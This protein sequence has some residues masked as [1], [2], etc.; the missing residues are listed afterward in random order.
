MW[1]APTLAVR[2]SDGM[3]QGSSRWVSGSGR[4]FPL[5]VALCSW[6]GM[7]QG[8]GVLD[9]FRWLECREGGLTPQRHDFIGR[10]L[11]S[12]W[13]TTLESI[14]SMR[15][16]W[17][18]VGAADTTAVCLMELQTWYSIPI[19]KRSSSYLRA[20][21]H[22]GKPCTSDIFFTFLYPDLLNK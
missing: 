16:L 10:L 2:Y 14:S 6:W 18:N 20:C 19:K 1:A 13:S 4:R 15:N 12:G 9:H 3:L 17:I 22:Q 8:R 7:L 21:W 11:T 5:C